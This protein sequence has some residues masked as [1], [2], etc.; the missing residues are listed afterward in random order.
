MALTTR[1]RDVLNDHEKIFKGYGGSPI[2]TA[3]REALARAAIQGKFN[4]HHW[5][6]HWASW[7]VM[8]AGAGAHELMELGGW[9][10][11][12]SVKHYVA[13]NPEHLRGTLARL[14]AH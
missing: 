8:E 5:R 10:S 1:Q 14:R 7:M 12:A 13:L 3:H 11:P 6:S 4:V 2:K 9:R